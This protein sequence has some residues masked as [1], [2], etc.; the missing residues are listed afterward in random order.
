MPVSEPL[1]TATWRKPSPM[2][3]PRGQAHPGAVFFGLPLCF[4]DTEYGIRPDGRPDVRCAVFLLP[5]GIELRLW[6]DE[7]RALKELPFDVKNTVF[8]CYSAPA[9]TGVF[10]ELGLPLP[11]HVC[12][13][14]PES[15]AITNS[16]R[17]K[18]ERVR[19]I[20]MLAR[21]GLDA[22]DVEE[23][24][25]MRDLARRGP[26]YTEQEKADLLDYC[27]SDTHANDVL[28]RAMLPDLRKFDPREILVPPRRLPG[29]HALAR[30]SR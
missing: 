9:E 1:S 18:T 17:R 27:A 15:L 24:T 22:I 16:R 2:G 26:P 11:H 23:K 20:D 30:G 3:G 10:L 29:A 6:E 4:A 5:D 28:L 8:V 25:E 19:L 12:D 7:L 13:L 14:Y 21:Y